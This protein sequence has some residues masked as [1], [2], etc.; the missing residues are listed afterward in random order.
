MRR[1]LLR[2]TWLIGS[3][4]AAA[5]LPAAVTIHSG[6]PLFT[7]SVPFVI[8]GTA[9][10]NTVVSI[11]IAPGSWPEATTVAAPD[12]TWSL[13]WTAP[14]VTGTYE[15]EARSDGDTANAILRVQLRDRL[16]RRPPIVSPPQYR[17]PEIFDTG[18]NVELT[19]RWRIVP[20]PYELDETPRAR[21]IGD[22][23]ATLDP[24]NKNLL[25]GDYPIR[26]D[27]LFLVLTAISDSMVEARTIPT[28]S[29]VSARR[30]GSF[31][32]FGSDDQA[33][34]AQNV[35]LSADLFQGDTVFQPV[36]QRLKVTLIGN[37]DHV[38]VDETGVLRPDVRRGNE[39]TGRRLS[40]QELFYE[41]KLRDLSPNY[42]F[43]SVRVGSQPFSS[44]FRG[45][46]FADTNLGVRFFG[47][48]GSNR[49]QYNLAFFERM[50]KDTN[51]GLNTLHL[52]DQRVAVAN[53]YWQDFLRPGYTQQF[54]IHHV[55][56]EGGFHFDSNGFLVRPAPVGSFTPH[57][58]EAT[59]LG[60]AGF[61]H[62]GRINVDHAIYYVFGRD[63][64]NPVAGPDPELRR[65]D[66][67]RI[68]AGMAALELS[69]DRDWFR[70]RIGFFY[71]SGDREPRDRNGR[72]FDSIADSPLFA[73]GGFS[74]FNRLG[75]RLA[76]SGVSLVERGSLLPSLRS[77]K[78]QGQPNYVNPGVQLLTAGLDVEVTPRLKAVFTGNYIRLDATEPL[79]EILFQ[80]EIDREIGFDLSA[81]FRYR[82]FL[83]N[84]VVVVGGAAALFPGRGFRD[85]Y[86]SDGTLYHVFTNLILQF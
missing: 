46:V 33:M 22:R 79:E 17:D 67:I 14:I 25:K 8:R 34:L 11:T 19:D 69:Y 1:A 58:V 50:E 86:E 76:G 45:F 38:R 4:L 51:S 35:I 27:D 59:Y 13:E 18:E 53:F 66:A 16:P 62:F 85:I 82:P 10:P 77:S 20:P 78:D 40:L 61:G 63:S 52:R 2:L 28:P 47:N 54:S 7:E 60:A 44:D 23:G 74:F 55:R 80:G 30:P 81:G 6:Q 71:A 41:R 39:R 65:G 26:G 37:I 36:R 21:A 83:N 15:I 31:P 73:G 3:L 43:A 49:Y 29:G 68:G 56:D 5:S 12:G 48:H 84:N 75:I 72:G 32:F 64:H 9:A 57:D 42:D 70:P 24:Y